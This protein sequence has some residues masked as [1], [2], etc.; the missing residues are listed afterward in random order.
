MG[1]PKQLSALNGKPLIRH[2]A[3]ALSAAPYQHRLAVIPP[4]EVGEQIRTA[5]SD[6]EFEFVVNPD[7]ARGLL[8][9]FCTAV[10]A[11][12]GDLIGVNFTLA[13]MPLLTTAVHQ[14]MIQAF[15]NSPA[16]DET[17]VSSVLPLQAYASVV[18][19][20]YGKDD[21][22]V[23]AP[24]HLLRADLLPEILTLPEADHGPREVVKRHAAQGLTLRFPADLLLD[25]DTPEA[26]AAAEEKGWAQL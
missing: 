15:L 4:G 16:P 26:L 2:A 22:I 3:Q 6:L 23:R 12:P 13:D 10:G 21:D 14:A 1:S 25:I 17:R 9:S 19:A 11:L 8:S 5:L 18:L 20:E 24:P 7:P